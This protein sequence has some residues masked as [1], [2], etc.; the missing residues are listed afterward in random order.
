MKWVMAAVMALLVSVIGCSQATPEVQEV[1]IQPLQRGSP[2]LE[3]SVNKGCGAVYQH[4]EE[5]HVTVKSPRN[6]YLTLID[7]SP[8]GKAKV[9]FP[10]AYCQDNFVQAGKEYTIPGD[11][12]PFKFVIAPPDGKE[13]LFA[14]VTETNRPLTSYDFSKI[15]PELSGTAVEAAQA[16]AQTVEI[17]P[18]EE[19]WATA[20]CYFYIGSAP[21]SEGWGLFIGINRYYSTSS[22][23]YFTINRRVHTLPE[24]R[25]CVADAHAMA[26]ALS[27]QFSHQLVLLDG[28]ATYQ[29]IKEAITEWLAGAPK[30]A[31][32]LIYFAGHGARFP[33]ENGDEKDGWDEALLS[34]DLKPIFD[35][36]LAGW[37]AQLPTKKQILVLDT[38]FS[39]TTSW[40]QRTFR[41]REEYLPEFPELTDGFAEDLTS[42]PAVSTAGLELQP[43]GSKCVPALM[44]GAP[45]EVA[46]ENG[47]FGHGVFTFALLQGLEGEADLDGDGQIT[48]QE[49]YS[50]AATAMGDEFDQ[51]PALYDPCGQ[52]LPLLKLK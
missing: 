22:G 48:V 3:L 6:G 10:N 26:A 43:V 33:D 2:G 11:L 16:V 34:Y 4:G 45:N 25:Y 14:L 41:I 9:I 29:S 31:T 27:D 39:G 49:L 37:L 20:M 38:S 15:F 47:E 44:A 52:P 28:Q 30:D 32:V 51:H 13:I 23:A 46:K 36:E 50:Y 40:S 12:L 1:L 7:F 18:S 19:W 21:A 5:L 35:D 24:L 17:I 8:N 42:S